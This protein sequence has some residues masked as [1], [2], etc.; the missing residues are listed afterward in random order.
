MK[1][2]GFIILLILLVIAGAAIYLRTKGEKA[3]PQVAK[4]MASS[5]EKLYLPIEKL[6]EAWKEAK[7][8]KGVGGLP[9]TIKYPLEMGNKDAKVRVDAFFPG[10][11]EGLVTS[12]NVMEKLV[13]EYKDKLYVRISILSGR[14]PEL[15]GFTC[16]AIF[17]NGRNY[18]SVDGQDIVLMRHAT[19]DASTVEKA[20][21]QAI[22][23]NYGASP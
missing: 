19:H 15:L 14:M 16:A 22:K 6:E 5:S 13:E 20:I 2:V 21:R 10:P 4:E 1:R 8:T 17:I 3:A 9:I 12:T 7:R 18:I 23:E 11:G